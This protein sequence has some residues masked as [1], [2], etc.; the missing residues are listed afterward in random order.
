MGGC[1]SDEQFPLGE[2]RKTQEK[3]GPF[4]GECRVGS[5]GKRS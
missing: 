4:T 2:T 3:R 1:R 5:S